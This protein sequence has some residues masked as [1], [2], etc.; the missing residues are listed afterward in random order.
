MRWETREV[1]RLEGESTSS[2]LLFV[3]N[4]VGKEGRETKRVFPDPRECDVLEL[5][6]PPV[7]SKKSN[8]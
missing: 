6:L 5:R 2:G 3:P 7:R 8:M 4:W 1:K